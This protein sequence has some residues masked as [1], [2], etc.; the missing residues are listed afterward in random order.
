MYIARL[1]LVMS[2]ESSTLSEPRYAASTSR[3]QKSRPDPPGSLVRG[4][5]G[6]RRPRVIEL[7]LL[8]VGEYPR[9]AQLA[10][11]EWPGASPA[12]TTLDAGGSP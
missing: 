6:F 11:V 7:A 12:A 10:E 1:S 4:E 2:L 5:D 8:G 9:L 3:R